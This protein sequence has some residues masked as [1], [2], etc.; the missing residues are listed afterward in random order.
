[1]T[2]VDDVNAFDKEMLR[3]VGFFCPLLKETTF[4]NLR[5]YDVSTH[6]MYGLRNPDGQTPV[7]LTSPDELETIL[8]EWPKV[9]SDTF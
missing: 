6:A 7:G 1:M 3:A 8:N 4:L 2:E 9:S 5:D